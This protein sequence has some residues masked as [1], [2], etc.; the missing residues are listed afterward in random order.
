M[1]EVIPA[2]IARGARYFGKDMQYPTIV[3]NTLMKSVATP[4]TENSNGQTGLAS[5][6]ANSPAVGALVKQERT[7]IAGTGDGK[8]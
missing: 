6:S 4:S 3:Q 1:D 8:S 2:L 7:A 5:D